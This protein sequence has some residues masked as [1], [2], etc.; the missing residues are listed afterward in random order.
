VADI[1][2]YDELMENLSEAHIETVSDAFIDELIEQVPGPI[3]G[4]MED[5][6]PE[7]TGELRDSIVVDAHVEEGQ[8]V[9]IRIG[10]DKNI[11]SDSKLPN[12]VLAGIFEYGGRVGIEKQ[13]SHKKRTAKQHREEDTILAR[14]WMRQ[15]WHESK[16]E[17]F[18]TV[19]TAV[20]EKIIDGLK[21][22]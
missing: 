21:E 11:H 9:L 1:D 14:H 20:Q 8:G 15:S 13:R 19:M 22:E 4:A 2:G 10:P 5:N 7:E 3:V 12:D 17:T 18:D 6:C 16:D